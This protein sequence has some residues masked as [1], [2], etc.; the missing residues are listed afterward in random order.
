MKIVTLVLNC[1]CFE[2]FYGCCLLLRSVQPSFALITTLWYHIPSLLFAGHSW[3]LM[4][5][6]P[7]MTIVWYILGLL[8]PKKQKTSENVP[9]YHMWHIIKTTGHYTSMFVGEI[10]VFHG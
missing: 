7:T 5:S 8:G 4:E 9:I 6:R 1:S 10:S 3:L 2:S